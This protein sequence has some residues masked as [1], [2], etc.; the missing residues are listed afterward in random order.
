MRHLVEF[1]H[2]AF[3]W[4]REEERDSITSIGSVDRI[5]SKMSS[6]EISGQ[7]TTIEESEDIPPANSIATRQVLGLQQQRHKKKKVG[8]NY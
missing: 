2:A 6:R 1:Q 4:I 8:R 7:S 3:G 5:S